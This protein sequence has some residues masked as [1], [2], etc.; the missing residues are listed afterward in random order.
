MGAGSPPRR[1]TVPRMPDHPRPT[2]EQL[3]RYAE[4]FNRSAS[5]R[6]FGV[7]IS[8]PSADRVRVELDVKPEHLGGLGT[9]A[10]NGGILA[11]IFDLVIGS[12]PALL[13]PTRKTA[14]MQL[15]MSFM[16]P[17]RGQRIYADAQ[18]ESAGG[19]TLFSRALLFDGAGV[20]CAT[21]QGVVKMS[22]STWT[23]GNSPAVN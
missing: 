19:S 3:E 13:D 16:R 23:S 1:D 12:S 7:Q 20:I 4:E 6:H 22:R 21:C 18:V 9:D 11:A 17:V 10:V 14:T 15:S 2:P 5:L 8:F